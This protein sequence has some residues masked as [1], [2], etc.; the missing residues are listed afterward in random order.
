MLKNL[1]L[2]NHFVPSKSTKRLDRKWRDLL[3][4]TP[5]PSKRLRGLLLY[6]VIAQRRNNIKW[7]KVLI[8]IRMIEQ[9]L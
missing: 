1:P 9:V 5:L 7:M 8:L 2:N 6:E 3:T 4:P